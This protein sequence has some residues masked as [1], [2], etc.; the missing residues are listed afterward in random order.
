MLMEFKDIIEII[1]KA[2]VSLLG[3]SGIIY[4][5]YKKLSFRQK[6]KNLNKVMIKQ[7]IKNGS[8]NIQAGNNIEIGTKFGSD[9]K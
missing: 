8:N 4:V 1:A 3:T 5:A 7:K 6:N 2:A 9:E